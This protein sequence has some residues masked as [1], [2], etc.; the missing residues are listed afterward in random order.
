[1]GT[2]YT[3]VISLSAMFQYCSKGLNPNIFFNQLLLR[4]FM[5]LC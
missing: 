4:D 1:M 2:Q 5:K 3:F